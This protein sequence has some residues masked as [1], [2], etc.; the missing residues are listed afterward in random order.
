V[1]IQ[2]KTSFAD[3][4]S[5]AATGPN[6]EVINKILNE[7][8]QNIAAWATRKRLRISPEKSQAIFFTPHNKEFKNKPEIYYEGSLIPVDTT[9]KIL[10]IIFD[11]MHTFTPHAKAQKSKGSK[12][13]SLL[14]A[15]MGAAWGLK[16]EDG[17]TAFK[18]FISPVL[19]YGGP[20]LYPPRSKLKNPVD[21][22]QKVQNDAL[23]VVTGCHAAASEQH[24]YE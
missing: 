19:G 3:D 23:R 8:M 7:D 11:T 14:K 13:V 22:L 21:D 12:H 10:G 15:V 24:L 18:A 9:I 16:K 2:D 1:T 17:L 6:L 20:I 4:F 5:I